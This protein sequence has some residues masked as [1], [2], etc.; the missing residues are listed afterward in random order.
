MTKLV[1]FDLDETLWT[2]PGGY[3]ALMEAP[4]RRNGDRVRDAS[5]YQLALRPDARPTLD[6]L[7]RRGFLLSVAS[8]STPE[9]AGEILKLLGLLDRFLCPCF[10]WQDKD[11][12]LSRVLKDLEEK[13]GIHLAPSEVL[14]V[15]DWPSNIRDAAKVG[16]PGLVFGQQIHS[17]S[18]ILNYLNGSGDRHAVRPL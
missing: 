7:E 2:L 14:L 15:D 3:C 11:L 10:A 4:F 6:A 1:V 8:R 9:T 13:E 12:S 17:L 18:E 5:G 16:V